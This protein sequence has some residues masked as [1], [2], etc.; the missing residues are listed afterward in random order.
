MLCS[1]LPP[2]TL[3]FVVGWWFPVTLLIL[4]DFTSFPVL[5]RL[6]GYQGAFLPHYT[7]NTFIGVLWGS[8]SRVVSDAKLLD[9]VPRSLGIPGCLS[10]SNSGFLLY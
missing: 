7:W 6:A 4:V 3:R 1:A 2:H 9:A 8:S 10:Y 5:G